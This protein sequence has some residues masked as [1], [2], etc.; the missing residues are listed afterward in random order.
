MASTLLVLTI[1]RSKVAAT[2]T[3]RKELVDKLSKGE[4]TGWEWLAGRTETTQ[5]EYA[6]EMG[7][8]ARTAQRH[9]KKFVELGLLRKVGAGSST[10]YEVTP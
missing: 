9:L 2:A 8:T 3:L 6:K 1:Y 5:A 7:V 4:K 10:S